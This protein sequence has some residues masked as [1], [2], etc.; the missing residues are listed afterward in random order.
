MKMVCVCV[1][2]WMDDEERITC[3]EEAREMRRI[4]IMSPPPPG[5]PPSPKVI[6]SLKD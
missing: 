1:M 3:P 4:V 6:L 2:R 5:K